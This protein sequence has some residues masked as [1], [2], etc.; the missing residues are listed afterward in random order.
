MYIQKTKL[1]KIFNVN[2][3]SFNNWNKRLGFPSCKNSGYEVVSVKQWLE[4]RIKEKE[5]ELNR[6]KNIVDDIA[7]A[8]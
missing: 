6:L 1:A 7:D 5:E 8:A 4:S 2:P 3:H